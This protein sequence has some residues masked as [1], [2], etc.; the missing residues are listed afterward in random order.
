MLSVTHREQVNTAASATK[1]AVAVRPGDLE[2]NVAR[3]N[4]YSIVAATKSD[5]WPKIDVADLSASV[6]AAK[7]SGDIHYMRI[8]RSEV[9]CVKMGLVPQCIA[10]YSRGAFLGPWQHSWRT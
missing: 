1:K 10:R 6:F 4:E 9:L 7:Y 3:A 8:S 5:S 2:Y